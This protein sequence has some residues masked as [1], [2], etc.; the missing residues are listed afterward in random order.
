MI[1]TY[2]R[3]L[4][5]YYRNCPDNMN[6]YCVMKN[7]WITALCDR[8]GSVKYYPENSGC[9]YHYLEGRAITP[10]LMIFFYIR[11]LT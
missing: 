10:C 1:L 3:A 9:L 11:L 8:L 4:F 5:A 7:S 6:T 2:G